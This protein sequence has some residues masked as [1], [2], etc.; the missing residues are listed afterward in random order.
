MKVI[1]GLRDL[2]DYGIDPLTGE[3]DGLGFRVL[4]DVSERGLRLL[5]LAYGAEF[6]LAEPWNRGRPGHESV[7]SLMLTH[8]AHMLLGIFAL[9][10]DHCR[11]VLTFWPREH[12]AASVRKMRKALADVATRIGP[13]GNLVS[14]GG[15]P[16]L[17]HEKLLVD[18][19]LKAPYPGFFLSEHA[20]YGIDQPEEEYLP[21]YLAQASQDGWSYRSYAYRGTAR[22]R[23]V[24]VAS[25]RV[26]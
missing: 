6:K 8:D 20:V 19:A 3:A 14:P 17:L 21:A 9:L 2:V 12:P 4:C 11:L 15:D 25:G 24:H 18:E 13:E 22:D 16:S 26:T 5:N 1:G 10:E 23:N 7:G